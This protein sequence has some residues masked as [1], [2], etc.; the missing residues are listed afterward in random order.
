MAKPF[1]WKF[2]A[3]ELM[4]GKYI[5]PKGARIFR[6]RQWAEVAMQKVREQ[7][8][9]PLIMRVWM[10]PGGWVVMNQHYEVVGGERAPGER[11]GTR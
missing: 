8:S 3:R 2:D 7:Y 11:H 4:N 5:V 9:E 6:R 1:E 10:C